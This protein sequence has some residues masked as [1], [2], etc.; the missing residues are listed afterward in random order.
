MKRETVKSLK[1]KFPIHRTRVSAKDGIAAYR[2]V[3]K[4]VDLYIGKNC[5]EE[6]L[7]A[8][9]GGLLTWAELRF[10]IQSALALRMPLDFRQVDLQR[11]IKAELWG[12]DC[13]NVS[14]VTTRVMKVL[15]SYGI[16]ETPV[17]APSV[18]HENSAADKEKK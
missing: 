10:H 14:K 7:L 6:T 9:N 17:A 4:L 5:D 1:A 18:A 15:N 11:S 13:A 12:S 16:P 3:L 2:R 8:A